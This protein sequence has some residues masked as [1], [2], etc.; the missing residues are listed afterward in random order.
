[1]STRDINL[2]FVKGFLVI[3]MAM[4][5]SIS[6]F[7]TAGYDGTKW[8]RFVT[9]SFI[10]ISGYIVAVFYQNKFELN[11][12][13]ICERLVV[14][15]IKLLLVYTT[16][17]IMINLLG[18]QSHKAIHYDIESFLMSLNS[19]YI[20]GNYISSVFQIIVPIAY[21][22]LLSPVILIIH[23]WRKTI[24][25]IISILL[26][27][28]VALNIDSFNLYGLLIGFVGL[29]VGLMRINNKKPI[30]KHKAIIIIIF[31]ITVFM[32]K[33]FDRNI[34]SYV[35]G[36]M[37]ILKTIYDF[38]KNQDLT[39]CF[40]KIV[41]LLGQYSLLS[42]L[43]QIFFLQAIYQLFIKQRF[44]LGYEVFSI[45]VIV[46]GFLILLCVLLDLLRSKFILIDKSY[47]FIFS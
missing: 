22:L 2:D 35:I 45:F 5:H 14:R 33:Y 17:N 24:I 1:M 12:K 41:I 20:E 16:I 3:C 19:I 9:G 30:L 6:Y 42:Y 29:S 37:I 13:K 7:T 4:Y 8:L 36:I 47:K 39:N 31:F 23:K 21:L 26:F 10:F 34:I 44:G 27:A 43:M 15:G 18:I 38:A 25:F 28:Y 40:N 32:M 46:T 11:R